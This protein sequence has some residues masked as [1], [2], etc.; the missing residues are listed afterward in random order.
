MWTPSPT[1]C[2]WPGTFCI[3]CSWAL[4]AGGWGLRLGVTAATSRGAAAATTTFS[5]RSSPSAAPYGRAGAA[6]CA[7]SAQLVHSRSVV[8]HSD[9]TNRQQLCVASATAA[10]VPVPPRQRYAVSVSTSCLTSNGR[11]C[12]V[13][14]QQR[15]PPTNQLELL[16]L[17]AQRFLH[18]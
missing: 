15:V 14:Q 10:V 1:V 2:T 17:Q 16:G 18:F 13:L 4:R 5:P 6:D 7:T 9:Y 12:T 8:D 11:A 3:W